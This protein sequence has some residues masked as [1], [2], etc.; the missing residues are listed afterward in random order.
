MR[1]FAVA[2][3]AS[4]LAF[5]QSISLPPPSGKYRIGRTLIHL[6]DDSRT[7][8]VSEKEGAKREF[9]V[10]AWYPAEP[11]VRGEIRGQKST[12]VPPTMVDS[13]A[14]LI[15]TALKGSEDALEPGPAKALIEGVQVYSI[16]DALVAKGRWPVLLFAPDEAIFTTHYT[17]Y[18]EDLA[19]LGYMVFGLVPT[20]WTAKA[21][22]P[23]G[24]E[25]AAS[26]K[27]SND[28]SW[29]DKVAAPLWAGDL[30]YTLD[31]LL[32]WDLELKH[33]FFKH[34]DAK[35]IAAF[36]HG[37][38]GNVAVQLALEDKRVIAAADIDGT[39]LAT[40][41]NAALA[42]PLLVIQSPG[43]AKLE[44]L[45]R[46]GKP[47]YR[48]VLAKA[49]HVTFTDYPII[50]RLAFAR[51]EGIPETSDGDRVIGFVRSY[52][53]EFFALHLRGKDSRLLASSHQDENVDFATGP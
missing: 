40:V 53:R 10:I 27:R 36:G 2:L 43:T 14:A 1:T 3:L 13:E 44:A 42:K 48:M 34:I 12:W 22:F 17:S 32:H 50:G 47:G 29:L 35:K 24:H 39:P 20:A 45:Y 4:T 15:V 41:E 38:G 51:R 19:S 11:D 21:A 18:M 25:V 52:L 49:R 6:T 9:M 26:S 23:D 28:P 5:A 7:D 16:E 46:N 33:R 37:L 30:R 31:Q 8:P